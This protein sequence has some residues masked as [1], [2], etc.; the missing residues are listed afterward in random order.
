[1]HIHLYSFTLHFMLSV[2]CIN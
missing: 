2:L 1:M